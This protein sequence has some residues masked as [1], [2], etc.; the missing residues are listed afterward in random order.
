MGTFFIKDPDATLDYKWDWKA[1][2]NG[3]GDTD[4][5]E[6]T[7]TISS[8]ALTV[9]AS[10]TVSTSSES[11]GAVTAWLSGGTAGSDYEIQ[12]KITTS[13]GRIDERTITL[14]VRGR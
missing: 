7:E 12:C 2:T 6:S 3:T 13:T 9:P 14:K 4:W 8:F 1:S 11:S 5:L 10:I